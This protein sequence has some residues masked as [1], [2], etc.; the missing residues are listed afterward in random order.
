MLFCQR[1][2]RARGCAA[3]ALLSCR[4]Q[5]RRLMMRSFSMPGDFYE[6]ARAM[7]GHGA[8]RAPPPILTRR[9]AEIFSRGSDVERHATAGA[10][11]PMPPPESFD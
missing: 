8:G 4:W 2:R 1:R 9:P 11:W 7:R 6:H 3:E 10:R 5:R